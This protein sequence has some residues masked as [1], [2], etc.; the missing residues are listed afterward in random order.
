MHRKCFGCGSAAHTKKDRHHEH[1][2]H[3]YCKRPGHREGICMDKFLGRPKSQKVAAVLE[4]E[5]LDIEMPEGGQLGG[6]EMEV[7]PTTRATLAQLLAQ[8]SVL[9]EWIAEWKEE[10]F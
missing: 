6:R 10:D 2:L 4:E 8:Q 7:T 9:M 5:E 3:G 1:D